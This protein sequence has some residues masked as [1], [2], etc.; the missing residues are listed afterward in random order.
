MGLDTDFALH[1]SKATLA[2]L[3]N[4]WRFS[5]L[6]FGQAGNSN[7]EGCTDFLVTSEMIE[8]VA[9]LLRIDHPRVVRAEALLSS[10]DF[11][12]ACRAGEE[13]CDADHLWPV[14]RRVLQ[15]L[16]QA[17]SEEEPILCI[18]SA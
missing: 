10:T 6:F 7:D 17:V 5:D 3:R 11:E 12:A 13:A 15:S 14:Y 18:W 9:C 1:R 16:R 2:S 4:H 8:R